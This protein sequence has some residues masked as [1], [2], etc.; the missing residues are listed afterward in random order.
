MED[1]L[2]INKRRAGDDVQRPRKKMRYRSLN[3]ATGHSD[4][5]VEDKNLNSAS[6]EE[7]SIF[8]MSSSGNTSRAHFRNKYYEH[9]S[10]GAG[11]FGSVY[12]GWCKRDLS[13]VAI[14]HIDRDYVRWQQVSCN[15][16]EFKVI[17]EVALMLKAAGLPGSVGQPAAVSL[18]DWYLLDEEIILVMENPTNSVDLWAYLQSQGGSLSEHEAKII[19]KQLVD[20]AID[21]HSK[22]IFHRD[23]KLQNVLIQKVSGVLRVRIIDFGCGLFSKETPYK[24][25]CGTLAYCPP[26]WFDYQKYWARPTTV[27]QLGGVFYSLLSGHKDFTTLDFID[28]HIEVNAALSTDVKILLYMCLAVDPTLRSTLEELKNSRFL[29]NLALCLPSVT[30]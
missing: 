22:G 11:G 16:K 8:E 23:I 26:E 12:N 27:W 2:S 7:E 19:L 14:K 1:D 6:S 3:S 4:V 18:L 24:S 17:L 13:L 28:K 25:F 5:P 21:L 29:N 10:I 15:G 9:V 30:W 20:A